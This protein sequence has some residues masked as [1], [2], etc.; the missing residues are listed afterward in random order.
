MFSIFELGFEKNGRTLRFLYAILYGDKR[1]LSNLTRNLVRE[2]SINIYA[3]QS[4][5]KLSSFPVN[6]KCLLSKNWSRSISLLATASSDVKDDKPAD[7]GTNLS[8]MTSQQ[9][10]D[11]DVKEYVRWLGSLQRQSASHSRPPMSVKHCQPVISQ[12][13]SNLA[14]VLG[15]EPTTSNKKPTTT[16]SKRAFDASTD[17][18]NRDVEQSKHPVELS[19]RTMLDQDKP[20]QRLQTTRQPKKNKIR[21]DWKLPLMILSL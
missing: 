20:S 16:R 6:R 1:Y 10:I 4:L 14:N 13:S 2:K 21:W 18:E 3:E 17:R 5:V 7:L 8:G 9:S 19:S 11:N 12:R 15:T